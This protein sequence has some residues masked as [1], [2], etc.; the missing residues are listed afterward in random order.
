MIALLWNLSV[1]IRGY[2]RCYMPTNHAL[3][4][5]RSPRGLRWAIPAALVAAPVYLYGMSAAAVLAEQPGLG[6]LNVLV[7]MCSWNALKF[8]WLATICTMLAT[9]SFLVPRVRRLRNAPRFLWREDG[10]VEP[11]S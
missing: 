8:A 4:W 6:W 10:G 3:D 9:A 5:L 1:A 2:L 11:S 7:L